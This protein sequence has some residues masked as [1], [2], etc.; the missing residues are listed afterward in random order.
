MKRLLTIAGLTWAVAVT[1]IGLMAAPAGAA[2]P[3][4][5][6][7]WTVTSAGLPV[8]TAPDVPPRGLLVQGGGGGSPTA[9]AAVLY[10]LDP[11]TTA[12]TLTLTVAPSSATTPSATLQA[13]PLLQ[14]IVHPEQGGPMTDAPSYNCGR[15]ATA[16]PQGNSYRFDVSG[17]ASDSIVAVA[18]LPN[19]PVDRIV[20]SEPDSN[21]LATQP[22]SAAATPSAD[23]AA[24]AAVPSSPDTAASFDGSLG[25]P[26]TDNSAYG[27][28]SLPGVATGPSSVAP[29]PAAVPSRSDG[30]SSIPFF[31]TATSAPEKAA[32]LAVVLVVAGA[33]AGAALWMYAGRQRGTAAL[34]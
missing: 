2:A 3:R 9:V 12:T 20:L 15:K 4:D 21:S 16:A 7:W 28:V 1:T 25:S 17:L 33:L 19:G 6:G 11:G 13:C 14:P 29:A 30:S 34:S 24:S 26:A 5:Q 27:G 8:P 31:P 10:E 18:I 23:D 22:G 32:P